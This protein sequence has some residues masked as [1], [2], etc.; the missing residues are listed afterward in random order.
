MKTCEWINL[1][2]EVIR[3]LRIDPQDL[4]FIIEVARNVCHL[5][6]CEDVEFAKLEMIR[7]IESVVKIG[8]GKNT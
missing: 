5:K 6:H 7:I 1:E 8:V 4:E 2:Y 3:D